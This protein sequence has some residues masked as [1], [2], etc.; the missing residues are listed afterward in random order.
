[1]AEVVDPKEATTEDFTTVNPE[2]L[3][4]ELQAVYKSMQ[5][6]YTRKT[7][8]VSQKVKEFETKEKTWEEKLIAQ[9]ALEQEVNQWRSWYAGLSEKEQAEEKSRVEASAQETPP[10]ID[11]DTQKYLQRFEETSSKT[12]QSLKEEIAQL[13]SALKTTSDQTGRMFNYHAQ[14]V[15]L[16]TRYPGL[17]KQELLDYALKTG[18]PDL[19][20]AYK[21]LHQ[22]EMIESEITKRLEERLKTERTKGIRGPGQQIILRRQTNGPKTFDQA[23][24]LILQERAAQGL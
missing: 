3:A 16:G 4:P 5:A 2:T 14:L 24:E 22:D 8:A 15:E 13:K 7:Q 23:N 19:E 12:T 20:S 10:A 17:N 11:P 21:T 9:G 1:M 18:Q 6:D